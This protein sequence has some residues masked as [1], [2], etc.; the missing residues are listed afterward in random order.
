MATN[1]SNISLDTA[2]IA[3]TGIDVDIYS[4]KNLQLMDCNMMKTKYLTSIYY[5]S[6]YG[7]GSVVYTND[8]PVDKWYYQAPGS[9]GYSIVT[10]ACSK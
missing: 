2:I 10:K 5:D 4:A 7:E 8:A 6:L 9:A 1:S 3:T